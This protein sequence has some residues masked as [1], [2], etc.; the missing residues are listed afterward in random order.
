MRAFALY[1]IAA[2]FISEQPRADDTQCFS[3]EWLN[4]L[5]AEALDY[6][7]NMR[8]YKGITELAEAP[9]LTEMDD[10]IPYQMQIIRPALIYGLA[11]FME[12]DDDN[13][14]RA[15]QFRE[16]YTKALYDSQHFEKDRIKDVYEGCE[17]W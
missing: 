13:D 16:M 10:E 17:E 12:H 9:V 8:R 15:Q 2:S 11:S 6:E 14:F 4:I 1:Q 3:L 7:N 5:L